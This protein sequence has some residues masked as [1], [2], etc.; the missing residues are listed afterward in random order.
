[1]AATKHPGRKPAHLVSAGRKPAG[2]QAIWEAIRAQRDGFSAVSLSDATD[3]HRDTVKSYLT[4]LEAAGYIERIGNELPKSGIVGVQA[5]TQFAKVI[6]R[7][8]KDVGIDA[9][10]VTRDGKPV[11]Q[12]AGRDQMWRTLRMLAGDFTFRDL[13]IAASTE[14]V[15]VSEVDANDYVKHL[16]GA[17]YLILAQKG[18]PNRPARYRFNRAKNTGPKAPMV[19][20]LKT[21]FDPNLGKVVWQE[22]IAA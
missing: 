1:M 19:Q 2:R 16:A 21:V 3:I 5:K 20:R 18:G 12:G 4:G 14:E 8:V 11:I 7:L 10:R 9:P 15:P 22:E 6:F 17:G 13:A